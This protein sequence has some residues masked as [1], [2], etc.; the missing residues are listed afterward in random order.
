MNKQILDYIEKER[1][2]LE[3]K[4]QAVCKFQSFVLKYFRSTDFN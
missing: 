1:I 4:K 2:D 3:L